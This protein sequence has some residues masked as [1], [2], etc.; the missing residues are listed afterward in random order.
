MF[1]RFDTREQF[2]WGRDLGRW[3]LLTIPLALAI[4]GACAFFLWSLEEVTRFR[5]AHPAILF[6]LPWAGVGVA[7]IYARLGGRSEGGNNLL[8]DTVHRTDP[9]NP[10]HDADS[11]PLVPRRMAPIILGA[12]L[13]THLFGGSAG[14]E[15]TAVQ[16]GGALASAWSQLL[17]LGRDETR[18]LLLCGLAAGFGGVFGTPLAGCVFAL[19]VLS[20]GRLKYDALVPCLLAALVADWTVAALGIQH[21]RIEV[22]PLVAHGGRW[23]FDPILALKIGVASLFFGLAATLFAEATHAVGAFFKST[24]KNPLL[25]PFCGGWAIIALTYALGT[26][27]YLGLGDTAAPGGVSLASAFAAGGAGAFSWAWKLVFTALT[28]G[29]GF[30]GGEVTPLFFLGATLGNALS[31]PL[32]APVALMAALGFVAVFAGASNT[33]LACTLLGIELFG[34]ENAPYFALACFLSYGWSGH[35]GIY[36]SQ[37]IGWAKTRG[38]AFADLRA[39]REHRGAFFRR[40]S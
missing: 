23:P 5:G 15:G 25:R 4:G 10:G 20:L 11:S 39:A 2:R 9:E 6:A 36:L 18:L 30:K 8:I 38:A 3:L 22:A 13:V 14:R 19:E 27:D 31:V 12:T 34:A 29:S 7:W 37:R 17:R 40:G 24:V 21:A 33:P 32:H 28:L 16:M 26:R 35:S 1:F